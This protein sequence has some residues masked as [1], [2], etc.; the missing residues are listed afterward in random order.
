MRTV[1]GDYRL[2]AG[3]RRVGCDEGP[4]CSLRKWNLT[5]R[6]EE[7]L[8]GFKQSSGIDRL[9]WTLDS[10]CISAEGDSK[11][12]KIEAGILLGSLTRDAGA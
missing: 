7:T 12:R 8:K 4:C 3:I 9:M 2:A 11:K 10:L 5:F 1:G 6:P